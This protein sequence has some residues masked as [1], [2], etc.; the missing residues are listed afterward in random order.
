MTGLLE[1]ASYRI[2]KSAWLKPDEH[3]VVV[4][5]NAR[6]EQMTNLDMDVNKQRAISGVHKSAC[7]RL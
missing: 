5:V 4:R 3:D 7:I 6:M 1:T 2:S